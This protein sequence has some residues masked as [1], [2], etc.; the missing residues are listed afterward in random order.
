[1]EINIILGIIIIF[2]GIFAG[3]FLGL[4]AKEELKPGKKYLI[5]FK[6]ILLSAVFI[7]AIAYSANLAVSIIFGLILIYVLMFK[8]KF[9][10][11]IAYASFII[12]YFVISKDI[13]LPS[14]MFLY[15]LPTG[16]LYLVK[17]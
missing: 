7:I 15:G 8:S 10:D 11:L 1:M 17:D 13:L 3:Y 2:A 16:S 6:R 4:I 14:L 12:I 9:N 5:L